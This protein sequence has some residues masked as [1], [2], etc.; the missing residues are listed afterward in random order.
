MSVFQTVAARHQ[1]HS[2]AG[3][4]P[5]HP[6]EVCPGGSSEDGGPRP[7]R[8]ALEL[9][10]LLPGPRHTGMDLQTHGVCKHNMEY[11]HTYTTV[12][13]TC[14]SHPG[15][16]SPPEQCAVFGCSTRPWDP[17]TCLVQFEKDGLIQT[18]ERSQRR[19]DG[20]PYSH[21]WASQQKV[22]THT[23][24]QPHLGQPAEGTHTHTY[25]HTQQ[26]SCLSLAL[27]FPS[28]AVFGSYETCV[29]VFRPS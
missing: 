12:P 24:L 14:K 16:S 25:T 1:C 5:G 2:G 20:L 28:W 18:Q 23:V 13:S 29:C 3:P 15:A 17:E 22:H 8:Q 10:T 19:H 7:R 26:T 27:S 4:E 11:T 6:G 9:Q 21:T